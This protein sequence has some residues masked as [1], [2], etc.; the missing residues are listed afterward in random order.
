MKIAKT[1]FIKTHY[2]LKEDNAD[3]KIIEETYTKEPLAF[4]Y[5]VGMMIPAF[6]MEIEGM[7]VGETKSFSV[8]AEEAYG[9]YN[10]DNVVDLP[11]ENFG[12]EEERKEH[13]IIGNSIQLQDNAGNPHVGTVQEVTE[14]QVKIDFN[15]PMAGN[16]LFF[17]VEILGIRETSNEEL[18]EMGLVFES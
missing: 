9:L 17:E 1:N 8:V 4:V 18:Q 7:Q 12:T 14:T 10:D 2:R 16:D 5:G 3:G 13:L 11:I 6:E 15:H